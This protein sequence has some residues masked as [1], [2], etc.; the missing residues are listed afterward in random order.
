MKNKKGID[1]AKWNKITDYKAV[2]DAGVQFA[3]VKVINSQN[4]PDS[5]FHEHIN[6]MYSVGLPIT[7]GYTYVYANTKD[8]SKKSANA[9]VET[10]K[11]KGINTMWLDLEDNAVKGLGSKIIDII[12]IYK[13]FADSASMKFGIYT[14]AQYYNPYLKPYA[15]EIADIPIWWARYPYT[16]ER[17]ITADVP[18]SKYLPAGMGIVGWQYSSKGVIPGIQGYTDLNIW[19]KETFEN[20]Q[21]EIPV[22]YNPFTEPTFNVAIGKT[23]NDASWVQWYLWRFGK[24]TNSTGQADAS[25]I[26][27]IFDTETKQQVMAVQALLGLNADGIVGKITR[28]VWKKI[29]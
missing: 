14:G 27:G 21:Q 19:Y 18:D 12:E 23:G 1:I 7:D 10:A 26:N 6:G 5:R 28:T 24:L 20:I 11:P 3:I 8:K 25:K 29:C 9:F 4:K 22:E 2:R 17:T 15:H 16:K 13:M